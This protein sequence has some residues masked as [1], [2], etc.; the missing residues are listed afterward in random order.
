MR[1]RISIRI[2]PFRLSYP[3]VDSVLKS[4]ERPLASKT[5]YIRSS[6]HS[7]T[8]LFLTHGRTYLSYSGPTMRCHFGSMSILCSWTLLNLLHQ[9]PRAETA[10]VCSS[11]EYNSPELREV[12]Q[13]FLTSVG[14]SR[15]T[16]RCS[17]GLEQTLRETI[18]SWQLEIPAWQSLIPTAVTM[19]EMAYPDHPVELKHFIAVRKGN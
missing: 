16:Y 9:A 5:L 3:E 4:P 17:D 6:E 19:A 14:Y 2:I 18:Q 11:Q 12:L 1:G 7:R 13:T 15:K 10:S 8:R